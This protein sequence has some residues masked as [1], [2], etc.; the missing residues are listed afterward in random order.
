[1]LGQWGQNTN[2]DKGEFMDME[3]L[4]SDGECNTWTRTQGNGLACCQDGSWSLEKLMAHTIQSGSARTTVEDGRRQDQETQ[5]SGHA[6]MDILCMARNS[7]ADAA[8]QNLGT[9]TLGKRECP[10]ISDTGAC[11]VRTDCDTW[12]APYRVW[13]VVRGAK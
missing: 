10:N 11:R 2:L 1:M 4:S 7:L 13:N 9:N 5:R 3:M 12:G 8:F 6:V